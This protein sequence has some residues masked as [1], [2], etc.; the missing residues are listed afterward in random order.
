MNGYVF[1]V[2]L[3]AGI[4]GPAYASQPERT[5]AELIQLA[6]DA[7]DKG[8]LDEAI[9]LQK[10]V[11]EAQPDNVRSLNSIAGL[12][13]KLG[14]FQEEVTWAKKATDADPKY[15]PALINLGNGYTGLGDVLQATITYVVVITINP[16]SAIGHYSLGVLHEQTGD[17]ARAEV[18]CK[19]AISADGG[20]ESAYFNLGALCANQGRFDEAIDWLQR[21]LKIN[22][23][24]SD[25]REMIQQIQQ[26][27]PHQ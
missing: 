5:P 10:Q 11:V 14:K 17:V 7:E 27:R 25:A 3:L 21:L 8:N 6:L 16:K 20:F 15:E 19:N 1:A 23:S 12:Y 18:N 4:S 9:E 22:P 24:A 13:G 2:L 26:H